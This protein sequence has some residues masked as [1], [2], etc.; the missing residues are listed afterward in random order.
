MQ[1]FCLK[2]HIFLD[3][4][5]CFSQ[6]DLCFVVLSKKATSMEKVS[7]LAETLAKELKCAVCSQQ[8]KQPKVLPC[9]HSFCK[10]CL[11]GMLI[12]QGI[13]WRV[14]CPFCRTNVE[15]S[16]LYSCLFPI[17]LYS[18]KLNLS[19]ISVVHEEVNS[20]NIEICRIFFLN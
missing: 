6:G 1:D 3:C 13:G 14:G 19:L 10:S 16:V 18:I 8:Y 11:E 9:L 15:V 4:P 20:L 12:K 2:E 7:S 17:P 5:P